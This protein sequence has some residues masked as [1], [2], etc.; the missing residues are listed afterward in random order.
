MV[1]S[2]LVFLFLFFPTVVAVYYL[3][4]KRTRNYWL[5]VA[6]LFFY[7]YGEPILIALLLGEILW[8]YFLGML[9]DIAQGKLRKFILVVCLAGDLGALVWFKYAGFL[10]GNLTNLFGVADNL[11]EI[12]LPIGISFYTFQCVSYATDV[13]RKTVKAQKNLF[14]LGLYI[15]LFP[16]L[17]AGPIVR[18]RDVQ[19]QITDRREG[20]DAFING[21][22]RFGA[23]LCKKVILADQLGL[24]TGFAFSDRM[25]LEHNGCLTLLAAIAFTLQLYFDFSGYSDMAIGLCGMFGFRLPENFAEPYTARTA[26]DFWRRWHI[27][28][29][30]WFRD[31]V[32]IPLG[33]SRGTTLQTVRNMLIVWLLTGFWHGANWPCVIWGLAWGILLIIEKILIRPES[34]GKVFRGIYRILLLFFITIITPFLQM[35]QT[36]QAV[37]FIREIFTLY[38]WSALSSQLPALWLQLHNEWAYLLTGLLIS[39]GFFHRI[40][41]R[42]AGRAVWNRAVGIA[43]R[44]LV[45]LGIVVSISSILYGSYNPFLY[46]Q[47]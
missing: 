3:C 2:S 20:R 38:G 37:A 23:G 9:I 26:T 35:D 41:E 22:F 13:C 43:Y 30:T 34:K 12:T 29:S 36:A 24:I 25:V 18:Y 19:E 31:Y 21:F 5:L 7:G 45:C 1:F 47:F 15:S 17:I 14:H 10:Y 27:S 44:A 39:L 16:Q 46:F 6:S 8:N 33:G 4:P 28:L 11:P 42:L 32:Y 40:R